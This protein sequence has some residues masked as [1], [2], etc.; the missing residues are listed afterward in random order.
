[1]LNLALALVPPLAPDRRDA[2]EGFLGKLV[3]R[4][5]R[6]TRHHRALREPR[7]LDDRDLDGTKPMISRLTLL[8]LLAGSSALPG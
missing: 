7:R 4:A 6:R 5:R 3:L 1:M 2:E 8:A